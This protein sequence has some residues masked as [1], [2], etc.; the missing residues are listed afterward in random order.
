MTRVTPWL[1][2]GALS[3]VGS[4]ATSHT[5]LIK[6][7][8]YHFPPDSD[9]EIA[10]FNGDFNASSSKVSAKQ[11]DSAVVLEPGGERVS[12]LDNNW[13]VK[14]NTTYVSYRTRG[15][16]TYLVG[17]AL[18]QRKT[19]MAAD[20]FND[21]L[22][23]EGL[24]EQ[25]A[26]REANGQADIGA[27]ERYT[28]FAKAVIQVGE[29]RSDSFARPIGHPVEIIPLD[30]PYS[31]SAGDRLRFRILKNG[32]PLAGTRV[33]A[34]HEGHYTKSDDGTYD[35]LVKTVSDR[36]GEVE[37]EVSSRG[38]W[39]VRFIDLVESD[40]HEYWYS[41]ILFL[42]GAKEPKVPYDSLWATLTFEIR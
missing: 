41:N 14:N 19:H 18:K 12:L 33:F 17:M 23:Y 30:N 29:E 32:E 5:L 28:K 21:Y 15:A 25:M 39:Y 42:L 27:F 8:A 22:N 3:I 24:S 1:L 40:E 36:A 7:D 37:F 4:V 6:P 2:A 16:G 31:A 38:R 10:F 20:K 34:S 9:I 11:R 26:A 35:E 13:L